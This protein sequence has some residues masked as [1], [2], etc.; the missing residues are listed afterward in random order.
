MNDYT[1]I[2]YTQ[3]TLVFQVRAESEEEA[4]ALVKAGEVDYDS[5][6]WNDDGEPFIDD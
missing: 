1:V 5:W 3:G 6:E 4:I 2:Q